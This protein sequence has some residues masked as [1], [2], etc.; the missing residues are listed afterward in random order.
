MQLE[1]ARDVEGSRNILESECQRNRL[2]RGGGGGGRMKLIS[3]VML[4]CDGR[5]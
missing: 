2:G 3:G 5:S 4:G 1:D